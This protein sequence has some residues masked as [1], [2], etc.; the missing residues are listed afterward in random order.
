MKYCG[1]VVSL[2]IGEGC[3]ICEGVII[4]LGIEGGGLMIMIG[5]NCVFLVNLYVGYDSY[6][7]DWVVLFN[8]VMIVGYVEVGSYVI[9]GGGLVVI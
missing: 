8:N 1:E 7:G 5:N 4:N 9:F 6:L 2:I 3:I